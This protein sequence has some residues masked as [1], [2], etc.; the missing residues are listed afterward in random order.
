MREENLIN[1]NGVIAN[2][3]AVKNWILQDFENYRSHY[4]SFLAESILAK[5]KNVDIQKV[6]KLWQAMN[7]V[8]SHIMHYR[9]V[10]KLE[11]T[12]QVLKEWF[13]YIDSDRLPG[14]QKIKSFCKYLERAIY[15]SGL[16][17]L[18][19]IPD[20]EDLIYK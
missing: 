19:E 12:S 6:M 14:V 17:T 16:V 5:G 10:N 2:Y 8:I 1:D 7:R 3:D 20:Y 9:G 13:E 15:A 11:E 4:V 18:E